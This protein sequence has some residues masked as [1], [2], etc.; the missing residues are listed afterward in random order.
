MAGYPN[1][2]GIASGVGSGIQSRL[3]G[4]GQSILSGSVPSGRN[5]TAI[6]RSAYTRAST[7]IKDQSIGYVRGQ[8]GAVIKGI[9]NDV[10]SVVSSNF[11]EISAT[12]SVASISNATDSLAGFVGGILDKK[13][14]RSKGQTFP[15]WL[16]AGNSLS[17][18][19][20]QTIDHIETHYARKNLWYIEIEDENPNTMTGGLI[21]RL[22]QFAVDLNYTPWTIQSEDVQVGSLHMDGVTGSERTEIRLTTFDD[23][24]GLLQKWFYGKCGQISNGDGTFGVPRDYMLKFRIRK[25]AVS[26]E[27]WVHSNTQGLKFGKDSSWDDAFTVRPTSIEIDLSRRDQAL[28]E[29]QMTFTQMDTNIQPI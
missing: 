25:M 29:L 14:V 3:N 23:A 28:Q 15:S 22:N 1:F 5:L 18:L 6:A 19:Q 7:A 2:G 20:Q 21:R 16:A 11:T 8:V 10:S 27:E 13:K 26:R 12:N 17:T 4:M 9:G 24:R